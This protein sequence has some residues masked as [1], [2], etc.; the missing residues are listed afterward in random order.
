LKGQVVDVDQLTEQAERF[1]RRLHNAL[2]SL[3][4]QE[5]DAIVSHYRE[6]LSA[7]A[8]YGFEAIRAAVDEFGDPEEIA[9][10]HVAA[11]HA[12]ESLSDCRSLVL[13][14]AHRNLPAIS[15]SIPWPLSTMLRDVQATWAAAREEIFSG[16]GAA[17]VGVVLLDVISFYYSFEPLSAGALVFTFIAP[18]LLISACLTALFRATL[19]ETTP[20]WRADISLARSTGIIAAFG[21]AS[22]VGRGGLL[23]A[24]KT[25]DPATATLPATSAL[26]GLLTT[27]LLA[28]TF[29]LL[30]PGVAAVAANR[31]DLPL[32]RIRMRLR[33]RQL[34]LTLVT[35]AAATPSILAHFAVQGF[36][37]SVQNFGF[38]IALAGVDAASVA[39]GLL[40]LAVFGAIGLRWAAG[41]PSP[42]PLPFSTRQPSAGEVEAARMRLQHAHERARCGAHVP[43]GGARPFPHQEPFPFP[44]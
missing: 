36:A 25:I 3:P 43:F 33:R 1:L 8:R 16:I 7:K 19:T 2:A 21:L 28:L 41:D 6:R 40:A 39:G 26:C 13:M 30:L 24:V 10:P 32:Q 27:A 23:A 22:L 17:Y 5:K 12:V 42:T 18:V 29:I 15:S 14:P 20:A 34:P 37:P 35:A 4:S 9:R 11:W 44:E 31:S 38:R